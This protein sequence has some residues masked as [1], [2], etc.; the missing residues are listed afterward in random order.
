MERVII[1]E[2]NRTIIKSPAEFPYSAIAYLEWH[3]SCGCDWTGTGFMV[4]KNTL[5]TAAHCII[6]SKHGGKVT[7][8]TMYFGY[9]SKKNYLAKYSGKFDYWYGTDFSNGDGTYRYG[10]HDPWDYAYLKLEKDIGNKTGWFGLSSVS[11]A[12]LM[13]KQ[14]ELAGYRNGKLYSGHDTLRGVNG[15]LIEL[16]HDTE[17]GQSG[18]PLF[19]TSGYAYGFWVSYYTEDVKNF[20]YRI[21]RWLID[22]MRDKELFD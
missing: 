4:S 16:W 2:D 9:K 14:L 1:G 13:T 12:S 3:A 10:G 22:E 18:S 21:N 17:P 20:A 7:K 19:D 8:M 5:M 6:C 15:T 11:D